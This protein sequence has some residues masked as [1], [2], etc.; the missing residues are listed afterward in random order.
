MQIYVLNI[1]QNPK[2]LISEV[3]VYIGYNWSNN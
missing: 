1:E 2:E 3:E